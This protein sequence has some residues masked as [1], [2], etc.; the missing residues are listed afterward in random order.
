M[1]SWFFFQGQSGSLVTTFISILFLFCFPEME[2]LS[3]EANHHSKTTPRF[4]LFTFNL[5]LF[6][7]WSF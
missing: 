1:L 7:L 6:C 5:D 4:S 3:E 2:T